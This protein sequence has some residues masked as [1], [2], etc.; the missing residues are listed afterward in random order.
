MQ[1]AVYVPNYGEFGDPVCLIELGKL[2]ERNGWAGFF[3][4]DHIVAH[5]GETASETAD[6]W[7]VLAAVAAQTS[8]I[9]LGVL[10]TP[11]ARH[12]AS[13][14]AHEAVTL[15]RL[16]EGRWY[17]GQA[18]EWL[19]TIKLSAWGRSALA[20]GAVERHTPDPAR[21][22]GRDADCPAARG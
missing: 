9:R 20:R 18:W 13:K 14:V 7:L 6:S 2:A 8:R 19:T 15:D 22:V 3:V 11:L 10:I 4:W 12:E 17:S 1:H 21:A 16:S 5:W